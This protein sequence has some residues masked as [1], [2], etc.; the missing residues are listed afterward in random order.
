MKNRFSFFLAALVFACGC[1][2]SWEHPSSSG[3]VTASAG[4]EDRVSASPSPVLT[5]PG[6]AAENPTAR[7]AVE[8][9]AP[10][11]SGEI[12]EKTEGLAEA[13]D[14]AEAPAASENLSSARLSLFVNDAK[15]QKVYRGWPLLI[16]VVVENAGAASSPVVI[17]RGTGWEDVFEIEVKDGRGRVHDWP[18]KAAPASNPGKT[19]RIAPGEAASLVFVIDG[20]QMQARPAD[21][22]L[23]VILRG[24]PPSP[25][26]TVTVVNHPESLSPEEEGYREKLDTLYDFFTGRKKPERAPLPAPP[27]QIVVVREEA[28]PPQ[29]DGGREGLGEVLGLVSEFGM[30][31]AY[32]GGGQDFSEVVP[33]FSGDEPGS[34]PA[35]LPEPVEYTD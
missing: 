34:E 15:N 9:E 21:Y 12:P 18:F 7:P 24:A 35:E 2:F 4:G 16:K 26:V 28:P 10:A 20:R 14:D 22:T 32:R 27:P 25:G 29:E 31:A 6:D 30:Q 3:D 19:L 8:R 11:E 1:G 23:S 17:S 33:D 5:D 13:S